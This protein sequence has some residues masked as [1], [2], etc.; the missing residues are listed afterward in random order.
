MRNIISTDMAIAITY[1]IVTT[2]RFGRYVVEAF[3][4][5]QHL[6]CWQISRSQAVYVLQWD[7]GAV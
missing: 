4:G 2:D 1:S 3:A 7:N 6:S 5:R